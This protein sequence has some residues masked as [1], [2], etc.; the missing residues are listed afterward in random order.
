MVGG[1]CTTGLA[2]TARHIV[3]SAT[4][5]IVHPRTSHIVRSDVSL[6][7]VSEDGDE[8]TWLVSRDAW[9]VEPKHT[10]LRTTFHK[11]DIDEV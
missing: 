9:R 8:K 5:G 3:G 10:S 6:E 4:G 7:Q 1:T 11:Q 2:H